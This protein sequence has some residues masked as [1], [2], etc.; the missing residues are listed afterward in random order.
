VLLEREEQLELIGAMLQRA[1]RGEGGALV[2]EGT[3]GLGK[4]ALL[5]AGARWRL[6]GG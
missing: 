6:T 5:D 1:G 2:V 3:A 4:T